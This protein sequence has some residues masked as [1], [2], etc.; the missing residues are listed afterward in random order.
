MSESL[1]E[2]VHIT[3]PY[4]PGAQDS[5]EDDQGRRIIYTDGEGF[6][7]E[8]IRVENIGLPGRFNV[9]NAMAACAIAI[10]AGVAPISW[11]KLCPASA[12]LSTAWNLWR[13]FK[14]YPITTIPRQPT[15]RRRTW[16]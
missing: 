4:A 7:H 15:P 13:S 12:A 3:P 5:D 2:G 14:A 9:G 16:L 11:R 10:A 1:R 6:T 8:I